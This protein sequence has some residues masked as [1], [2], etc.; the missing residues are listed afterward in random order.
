MIPTIPLE[1]SGGQLSAADTLVQQRDGPG[2]LSDYKDDDDD[3]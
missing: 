3:E 1:T 2:W